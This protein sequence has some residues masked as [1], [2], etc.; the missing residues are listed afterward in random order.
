MEFWVYWGSDEYET[1]FVIKLVVVAEE[2]HQRL[3]ALT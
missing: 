1:T 3:F 2:L